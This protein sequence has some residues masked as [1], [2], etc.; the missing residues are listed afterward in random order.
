ML[1]EAMNLSASKYRFDIVLYETKQTHIMLLTS[2]K[3]PL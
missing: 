1:I 3:E 2:M